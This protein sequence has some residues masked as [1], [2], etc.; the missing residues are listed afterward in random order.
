MALK[1]L[2]NLN[3]FMSQPE[4]LLRVSFVIPT[5]LLEHGT[6]NSVRQCGK[7]PIDYRTYAMMLRS[8]Q[9]RTGPTVF[10]VSLQYIRS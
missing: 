5:Q 10:D 3:E 6:R 1:A 2:Q 7:T 9:D 4:I 8:G